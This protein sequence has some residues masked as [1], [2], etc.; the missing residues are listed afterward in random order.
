VTQ[1]S[2]DGPHTPVLLAEVV[3][4]LAPADGRTYVDGT[5]GAGGYAQAILEAADC[6]VIGI[7][8][9]AR[10]VEAA[11][12]L[13]AH[14]DG[15]LSVV[16]GRFGDLEGIL[17]ERKAVPVDGVTLDLGV[18]SMQLDEADRGFSF[19]RDG[20]LDMRMS[21]NNGE[22]AAD[23]VN[24]A[25]EADLAH[26]IRVYGE[27]RRARAVA[28][29]I[30][31]ARAEAPITRTLQ[32]AGI[33]EGAIGRRHGTQKIHPATRT[34][35][36]IR[37]YVNRELDELA[38]G[39]MAAE[40]VLAPGG[41]L[42]VVAF[43]SLEDRI[44]KSFINARARPRAR[45]SRHRAAHEEAGPKPSFS[46]LL[47]GARKPGEAEIA[48]NPRARSARLRAAERTEA[49]VWPEGVEALPIPARPD[50]RRARS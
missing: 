21:Q 4:A 44:V 9:D 29:A 50:G 45:G 28:R 19:R 31:A 20:P 10:A 41:R 3:A 49:P 5:F 7:D 24:S 8:R 13:V 32:L 17:G 2:P 42:A 22:S 1:L 18:S 35:Q 34:F 6:K 47:R 38:A 14:Y 16:E 27:E 43:H 25:T 12:A 37:I 39:L 11:A 15:R 48:A 26:I 46:L 36:A 33:V 23:V 30:T 40:R